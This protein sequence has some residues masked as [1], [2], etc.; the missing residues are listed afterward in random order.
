MIPDNEELFLE[1]NNIKK[2][3]P[4]TKNYPQFIKISR[5]KLKTIYQYG[6][7]VPEKKGIAVVGTRDCSD[8]GKKFAE[9]VGKELANANF[10]VNSGLARGI[11]SFAHKGCI[12]GGGFPM[13]FLAWFH[14][15]YPP[16]NKSL[17][18]KIGEVGCAISENLFSPT[19]ISKFEFLKRD[20]I[21]A[22]FSQVIV[23]VESKEKGGAKYTAT[24]A[25]NKKIPLIICDTKTDNPEL[26]N[27]FNSFID[28][29]AIVA[30]NPKEVIEIIK[31]IIGK[32]NSKKSTLDNFN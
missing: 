25:M 20:E 4:Y 18:E 7:P 8:N 26:K 24:Y 6:N 9:E 5:K 31:N 17:L 12:E 32:T 29:N 13:G 14:K 30:K 22:A 11:D 10:I 15:F 27:G 23:V 3:V 1:E 19:G 21:M 28:M 16:E 2:I